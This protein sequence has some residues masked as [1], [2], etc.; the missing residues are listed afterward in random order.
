M[1]KQAAD[2]LLRGRTTIKGYA[3]DGQ[4][5]EEDEIIFDWNNEVTPTTPW[6][7]AGADI[8]GDIKA[9]SERIQEDANYIPTLMLCGRNV[10][11]Y[12]LNNTAIK[13]WLSIPNRQNL[14]MAS[15]SPHYTTPQSRFIGYLSSLNLEIVSYS[16]TFVDDDGQVKPF[17]PPNTVIIGVPG[18]GKQ[19]YGAITLM[20]TAG[21]WNTYA[22]PTVPIYSYDFNAQQSSLAIFSRFLLVPEEFSE[23]IVMTVAS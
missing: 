19:L 12:L 23:W 2:I 11:Q 8:Y 16:E 20:D 5:I 18:R 7:Q 1:N 21:Q 4:T 13:E 3:D 10:E 14:N 6:N 17:L 22:A 15:F 9:C